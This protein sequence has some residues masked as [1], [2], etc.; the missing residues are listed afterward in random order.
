M[1]QGAPFEAIRL[2][3]LTP[4]KHGA[5]A[6][7]LW[8]WGSFVIFSLRSPVSHNKHESFLIINIVIKA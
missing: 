3:M 6:G 4:H 1:A 7:L 2:T 8:A 5:Y